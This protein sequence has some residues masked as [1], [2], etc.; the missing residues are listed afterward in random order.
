MVKLGKVL[1]SMTTSIQA[2]AHL[3]DA[4][5]R[6]RTAEAALVALLH[7]IEHGDRQTIAAARE[8]EDDV[9][10]ERNESAVALEQARANHAAAVKSEKLSRLKVCEDSC[11]ETPKLLE[12]QFR[13][14]AALRAKLAAA[15]S[16]LQLIL[17]AHR[18]N[19]MQAQKLGAETG[20]TVTARDL[21][22]GIVSALALSIVS[23][24]DHAGYYTQNITRWL[25]A[26]AD[27][28]DRA[29]TICH[30]ANPG[31]PRPMHLTPE[32]AAQV[33]LDA[34]DSQA[35]ANATANHD[36]ERWAPVRE[37][38]ER[39]TRIRGELC[40]KLVRAGHPMTAEETKAFDSASDAPEERAKRILKARAEQ[41]ERYGHA[42]GAA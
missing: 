28:R 9:R 11:R 36:R 42:L 30:L 40:E 23:E 25:A 10:G 38:H 31:T 19:A 4:E 41:A 6:A 14:V 39:V 37:Y 16:S 34:L 20:E 17:S 2:A 27:P 29:E 3:A 26:I 1:V 7:D 15:D 35:L 22:S 5:T 32:Q 12:K 21:E 18:E 8:R 13:N 33:Y 24:G